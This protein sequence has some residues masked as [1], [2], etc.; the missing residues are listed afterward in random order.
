[1]CVISALCSLFESDIDGLSSNFIPA[2]KRESE[3]KGMTAADYFVL[4][5]WANEILVLY[6]SDPEKRKP[7]F[8]KWFADLAAVQIVCLDAC[9]GFATDKK[10]RLAGGAERSTRLALAST[11]TAYSEACGLYI[12]FLTSKT[13]KI[14]AASLLGELVIAASDL[15]INQQAYKV[16]QDR[17]TDIYSFYTHEILGSKTAIGM[18]TAKALNRF[19]QEFLTA[20]DWLKE[21]AGPLERAILRAP[22][23]VLGPVSLQLIASVPLAVDCSIATQK[24]LINPLLSA[25]KS[26]KD[27][28]REN[29]AATLAELFKKCNDMDVVS[30]IASELITP[31]KTAKVTAPDQ[32]AL[33]VQALCAFPASPAFAKLIPS[34]LVTLASKE[35][36]EAVTAAIS[37]TMMHHIKSVLDSDNGLD[38]AILDSILKGLSDKR[39]NL[40]RL[41]IMAVG[42]YAIKLTPAVSKSAIEFLVAVIPKLLDTWKEIVANASAA[43]QSKLIISGYIIVAVTKHILDLKESVLESTIEKT[44][45]IIETAV[46]NGSKA[47]FFLQDRVYTKI[48]PGDE[49]LWCIRALSSTTESISAEKEN[50][51]AWATAF[52]YFIT[53]SAVESSVR[54]KAADLLGAAYLR[55]PAAVGKSVTL[56]LWKWIRQLEEPETKDQSP[57]ISA[58]GVKHLRIV[59]QT[60]T[61]RN[62]TTIPADVISTLLIQL[63]IVT[64]HKILSGAQDWIILCQRVGVDPG[65]LVNS[66]SSDVQAVISSTATEDGQT[67]SVID[68][69]MKAAAT[70]AF[71]KP[72]A[73]APFLRDRLIEDLDA[74]R[75]EGITEESVRI[76]HTPANVMCIDVLSKDREKYA[77]DKN[78]KDYA[79]LKWEAEV[80]AELAK[81]QAPAQKKLTKDERAKVDSQLKLEK[82]I[83]DRVQ[84][85]FLHVRRGVKL[86]HF[87]CSA[88]TD[89]GAE[90]WFPAATKSLVSALR[91]NLSLL[92]G[93]A[94]IDTFIEL[95]DKLSVRVG[96]L[97]RFVGVAL[98]R[99]IGVAD[100]PESLSQEPLRELVVRVLYKLRFLSEQIPL[101]AISLIYI[102]PLIMLVFNENGIECTN[103]DE[104]DEQLMLAIETLTF[105]TE[106][107]ECS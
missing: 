2:L 24:H 61:P 76:W 81:K 8:E 67:E 32:R 70:L 34:G 11:I 75:L 39:A 12:D 23:F 107:C 14:A 72:D 105:H 37:K 22:E 93:S 69:A 74:S 65:E 7:I 101:D 79:T 87:L 43:V 18:H 56:A 20:D 38:K 6:S 26:S 94:G 89:N 3:N 66:R 36:N 27:I 97:R 15:K 103:S 42:E 31:L 86:I 28:V 106:I 13:A 48:I 21:I 90:I 62:A 71:V 1:M 73:I 80:R 57:A 82:E 91:S 96:P 29:S 55:S 88:G 63:V 99:A 64:H 9:L 59:L 49:Q 53:G 19:F 104:K 5:E 47:S 84:D 45:K 25:L 95:S 102:L 51:V 85:A 83:R 58:A 44:S 46:A 30:R 41:W 100:V 4:L 60:I 16:V 78:T 54:K 35:T 50:G 68:A 92:V 52:I 98:L 17:K 40:R 77:V 10:S 33:Y